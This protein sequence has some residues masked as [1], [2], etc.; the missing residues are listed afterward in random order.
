MEKQDV[1]NLEY[2]KK[3]SENDSQPADKCFDEERVQEMD[4]LGKD[5]FN[6]KF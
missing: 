3:Y 2:F 4:D 6:R 5:G 1:F